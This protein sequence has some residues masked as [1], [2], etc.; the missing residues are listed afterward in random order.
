MFFVDRNYKVGENQ[1][2]RGLISEKSTTTT[3]TTKSH[4]HNNKD[5]RSL[6]PDM[7]V[8]TEV[9]PHIALVEFLGWSVRTMYL[10]A[11]RVE[12][13]VGDSGL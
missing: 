3:T 9:H 6:S 11:C 13:T 7:R 4:Q 10:L 5:P 2:T 12:V 1:Q 8:N